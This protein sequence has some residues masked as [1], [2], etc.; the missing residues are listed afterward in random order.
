MGS[1]E[2]E[3]ATFAMSRRR[4]LNRLKCFFREKLQRE[5][6][7]LL[8]ERFGIFELISLQVER[9][10]VEV[11]SLGNCS[12]FLRGAQRF[13]YGKSPTTYVCSAQNL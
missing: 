2:F 11:V 12:Q 13:C 9:M 7:T 5:K 6:L 8:H 10:C 4:I 1:P 3:S